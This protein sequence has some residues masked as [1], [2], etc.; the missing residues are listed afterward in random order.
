MGRKVSSHVA[1]MEVGASASF[2]FLIKMLK[3]PTRV[4]RIVI[5]ASQNLELTN[6]GFFTKLRV[7]DNLGG[8]EHKVDVDIDGSITLGG[9]AGT[10]FT[11]NQDL[12]FEGNNLDAATCKILV[13][14]LI[15]TE[16]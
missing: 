9:V 7:L 14:F 11:L 5:S 3:Y 2:K 4:S 15:I 6:V 12:P 16:G 13:Q 1:K 10:E 8:G